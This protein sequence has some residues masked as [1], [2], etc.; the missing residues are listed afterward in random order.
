MREGITCPRGHRRIML[1]EYGYGS[2]NR[3]DGFSE[4]QCRTCRRRY[5]RWTGRALKRGEQELR[6]GAAWE[7]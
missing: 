3:H 6:Y 4:V 2:P 1:V 7:R 5:G